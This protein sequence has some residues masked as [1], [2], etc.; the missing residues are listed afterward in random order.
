MTAPA[1]VSGHTV[2]VDTSNTTDHTIDAP[3]HSEGDII[4][5]AIASDGNSDTLTAPGFFSTLYDNIPIQT[6][7]LSK[8]AVF[9]MFYKVAGASEPE[10]YTVTG[11]VSERA[12]MIAFAVTGAGDI[13]A[14]GADTRGSSSTATLPAVTTTQADCLRISVVGTDVDTTPHGAASTLTKLG[15]A[16]GTSSGTV[17]VYYKTLTNNGA[18]DSETVSL[19][20][21]EQWIS[22]TFALAPVGGDAAV[23]SVFFTLPDRAAL[24]L[25]PG[26]ATLTLPPGRGVLTLPKAVHHRKTR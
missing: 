7:A 6:D 3:T 17:S 9:A 21:T 24:T 10:T 4:Y 26:R 19:N 11:S 1:I 18:S 8:I 15:E 22:R 16:G 14:N 5:I 23:A 25:P 20:I 13:D 2:H 12:G